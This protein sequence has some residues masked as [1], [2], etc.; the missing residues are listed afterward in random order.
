M[1][2]SRIRLHSVVAKQ[3][4][5]SLEPAESATV[6]IAD[7]RRQDWRQQ[8]RCLSPETPLPS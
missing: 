4:V 6:V 8:Q 1:A 5:P 7:K 3:L 2:N